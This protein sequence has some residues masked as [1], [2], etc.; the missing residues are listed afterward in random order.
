MNKGTWIYE[1]PSSPF[2]RPVW[3]QFRAEMADEVKSHPKRKEAIDAL[4]MAEK[5]LAWIDKINAQGS[6]AKLNAA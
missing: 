2:D 3:E 5:H 6:H 4:K 1:E